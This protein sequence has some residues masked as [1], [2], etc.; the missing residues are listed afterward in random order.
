MLSAVSSHR[1]DVQDPITDKGKAS[2]KGRLTVQKA[3]ETQGRDEAWCSVRIFP[4][5]LCRFSRGTD[6]GTIFLGVWLWDGRIGTNHGKMRM[7]LR[8]VRVSCTTVQMASL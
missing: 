4:V 7:A 8:A 3:D 2:K 1:F 6:L 5:L